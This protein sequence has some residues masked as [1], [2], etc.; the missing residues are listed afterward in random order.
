LHEKTSKSEKFMIQFNYH[1]KAE[2]A[3]M[4]LKIDFLD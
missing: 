3:G 1:R 2:N 4:I